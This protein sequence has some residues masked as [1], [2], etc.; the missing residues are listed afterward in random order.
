MS[1]N[2]LRDILISP[3]VSSF[4]SYLLDFFVL[5]IIYSIIAY[6]TTLLI[7]QTPI[8]KSKKEYIDL[9][10]RKKLCWSL[11]YTFATFCATGNIVYIW[12]KEYYSGS[13]DLLPH[14]S[15]LLTCLSIWGINQLSIKRVL[16]NSRKVIPD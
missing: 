12:L 7:L 1:I 4:E 14:W 2:F 10:V 9:D 15:M 8:Y 3:M 6:L 11:G 5:I 16:S 13:V